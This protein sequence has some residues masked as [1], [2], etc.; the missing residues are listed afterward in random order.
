VALTQLV[1]RKKSEKEMRASE[2]MQMLTVEER[3][4][5]DFIKKCLQFDPK[6]RLTCEEALRHDWFK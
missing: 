1:F 2:I 3:N 5:F 4:M 6:K